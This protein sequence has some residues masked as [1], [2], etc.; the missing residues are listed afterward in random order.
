ML[1]SVNS[2]EGGAVFA[3]AQVQRKGATNAPITATALYGEN[4][5]WGMRHLPL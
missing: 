1:R 4:I 5:A 3:F 2:P